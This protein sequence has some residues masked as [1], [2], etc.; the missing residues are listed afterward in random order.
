[1]L[2]LYRPIAVDCNCGTQ[3]RTQHLQQFRTGP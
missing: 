1:V 3:T 2:D